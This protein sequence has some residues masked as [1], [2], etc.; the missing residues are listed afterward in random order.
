MEGVL[1][2]LKLRVKRGINLAV[3]DTKSSDPYLVA[4][5]DGQ[6][7][8]TRVVKG[9]CNPEWDDELTLTL[10]D[11]N[12]PINIA[13]YDK[14]SFSN[15]DNMGVTEIDVKP[16][17]KCLQRGLELKNL[18]DGTKLERVHPQKTNN[19]VHESCIVLE[20]G[21]IVQDMTLRLREVECG[22]VVIRMEL[23]PLPGRKLCV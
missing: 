3:R 20:N 19:L 7:T 11:P 13:V 9:N 18:P 16:Y 5:V 12:T 1:G 8:K 14:D 21:K 17:I 15:D 2:I 10:R 22:E 6:K 23:I 4:T